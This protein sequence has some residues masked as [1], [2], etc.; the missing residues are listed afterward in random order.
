[1]QVD[2]NYE[3]TILACSRRDINSQ[4]RAAKCGESSQ[5][6][7]YQGNERPFLYFVFWYYPHFPRCP[8]SSVHQGLI[9]D[10]E[11]PTYPATTD[12]SEH[13]SLRTM[14][15]SEG[16]FLTPTALGKEDFFP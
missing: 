6:N 4:W 5:A 12:H 7:Q 8:C 2:T 1:M 13:S 14:C 11:N 16:G 9:T 15:D 3:K 10:S